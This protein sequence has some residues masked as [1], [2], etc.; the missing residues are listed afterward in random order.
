MPDSSPQKPPRRSKSSSGGHTPASMRPL[1]TPHPSSP[2]T[3][4]PEEV[5]TSGGDS[6]MSRSPRIGTHLPDF[7]LLKE[8]GRGGMGV[9]YKARQKSLDRIVAIKMLRDDMSGKP[10]LLSRFLA[11][12]RA[13][14]ALTHPNIVAI[15]QVGE[16]V[17]GRFYAMEYVKGPTLQDVLSKRGRGKALP[18]QWS[19]KLMLPVATAVHYAH[20]RGIIHRDLKPSNI[21]I[22]PSGRPVILDFGIAKRMDEPATGHTREGTVVGTPTF[23]SPEQANGHGQIGPV[24]DV[25]ALGAILYQM[26][27]GCL[28]YEADTALATLLLVTSPAM[29]PVP[30][31]LCSDVPVQLDAI[32][33]K[34]LNKQPEDRYADA[35][36]LARD[37]KRF[38]DGASSL[39][40]TMK[41]Q[42]SSKSV[43]TLVA[44]ENN[45]EIRLT[46]PS[47]IIG[48]ASDCDLVIKKGDVS[49]RHC[50]ILL[51]SDSAEVEDLDS[52]NGTSVNDHPVTRQTLEDG[53][54]LEIASHAFRVKL[55]LNI[56]TKK[57]F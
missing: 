38:L 17:E 53:D 19:V 10:V 1:A 12:A 39:A 26:L 2:H 9:V 50:R 23:M 28:P 24:S 34:C 46:Q 33:M 52:A 21:M 18:T 7:E 57:D 27:T 42:E 48:R 41:V 14:A 44:E 37:L 43:L 32:C 16:C 54:V 13:A 5:D 35:K 30:S 15:Y 20:S 56:K 47:T 6:S 4:I 36:E 22:D 25:Y 11:E 51:R 45:L 31:D 8:L 40:S 55:K 3:Q 29:P 49:K